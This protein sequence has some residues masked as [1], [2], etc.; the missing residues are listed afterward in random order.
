M[1]NSDTGNNLGPFKLCHMQAK[2]EEIVLIR[3]KR[4]KFVSLID[5][6]LSK[7]LIV[8]CVVGI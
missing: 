4:I 2:S 5:S 7:S 3:V 6:S 1:C 8:P